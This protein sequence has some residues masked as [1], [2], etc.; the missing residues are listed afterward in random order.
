MS[1]LDRLGPRTCTA[2]DVYGADRDDFNDA[3][4]FIGWY[5]DQSSRRSKISKSDAYN[6]YLA[7]HEGQ[8]LRASY[9]AHIGDDWHEDCQ[10]D[11]LIQRVLKQIN[12]H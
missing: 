4:D 1:V 5:N 2:H 10:I 7:Y 9:T 3:I 6:L 12:H 11:H 8:G